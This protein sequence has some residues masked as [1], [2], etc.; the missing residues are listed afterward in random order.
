VDRRKAQ[1]AVRNSTRNRAGSS[2]K[3]DGINFSLIGR[4][5]MSSNFNVLGKVGTTYGPTDVSSAHV[6]P[7]S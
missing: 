5:P 1:H 6:R 4:A 3:M 7:S 2:T